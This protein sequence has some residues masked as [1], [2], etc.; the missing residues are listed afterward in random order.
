V[1]ERLTAR[2][3]LFDP[4]GRILLLRG[5]L[6]S[7]PAAPGAWFTVG[8]EV[9]AGESLEAAAAR[10]AAEET[11]FS[12]VTLGAPIWFGEQVLRLGDQRPVRFKEHYFVAWC[13]GAEPSRAGWQAHEHDL[14][15]DIRWWTPPDLAACT[16]KVFPPGLAGRLAEVFERRFERGAVIAPP[17]QAAAPRSRLSGQ[18]PRR[19]L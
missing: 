10:E 14:V 9:E 18:N 17:W 6:P 5:R 4:A 11:G 16:D 1:R 15:D 2:V 13:G 8:G 19:A 3:L 12:D 7:D